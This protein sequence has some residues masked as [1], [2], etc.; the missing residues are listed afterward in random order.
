[1]SETHARPIAEPGLVAPDGPRSGGLARL[2]F[3]MSMLPPVALI[4]AGVVVDGPGAIDWAAAIIAGVAA[5]VVFSMFG[6]MGTAMGMTRMDIF[7]FLGSAVAPP[8]S[9]S[10]K[11]AG[12]TMHHLNGAVLA[13]ALATAA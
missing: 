13:V 6:L 2:G 9:V 5:T 10:A 8:S 1:M 7:D 3:L 4:V 11:V 12:A